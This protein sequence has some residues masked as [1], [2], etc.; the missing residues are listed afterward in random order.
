MSNKIAMACEWCP[1]PAS[2]RV[3]AKNRLRNYVRYS[4]PKHHAKLDTLVN[5]DL[6]NAARESMTNPTGF[7][8]T[9]GRM[10]G[11]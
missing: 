9:T 2:R 8:A 10:L 11:P 3:K 6:G 7:D 5:C 1:A 4:C